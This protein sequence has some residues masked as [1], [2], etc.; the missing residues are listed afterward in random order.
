VHRLLANEV[1]PAA[2]V[3]RNREIAEAALRPSTREFTHGDL[4]CDQVF[5]DGDEVS[6]VLD[7]SEAD[8][9]EH[10]T[11]DACDRLGTGPLRKPH[12]WRVDG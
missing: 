10:N 11:H 6:G 5:V 3:M 12:S 7:W 1:L 4:Q 9:K 8:V 2:L